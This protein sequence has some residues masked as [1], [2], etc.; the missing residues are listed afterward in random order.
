MFDITSR[1]SFEYLKDLY[2]NLCVY[3]KKEDLII[4]VFGNKSD[5]YEK[6][7]VSFKEANDYCKIIGCEYLEISIKENINMDFSEKIVME[8]IQKEIPIT[9]EDF[10]F[11][12]KGGSF[13]DTRDRVSYG[14][15]ILDCFIN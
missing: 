8:C 5:L 10:E 13:T 9:K 3:F 7:S 12:K 1:E 15:H 6:R 2:R 11:L 14:Q 4:F